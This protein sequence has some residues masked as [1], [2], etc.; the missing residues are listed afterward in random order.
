M[1]HITDYLFILGFSQEFSTSKCSIP[2]H[3]YTS[4]LYTLIVCFPTQTL[5]RYCYLATVHLQTEN[6]CKG[7][8]LGSKS[9][10]KRVRVSL[11]D[12]EVK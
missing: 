2:P 7:Y 10:T 9:L 11:D 4:S 5:A 3:L 8:V 1:D 12:V 6:G